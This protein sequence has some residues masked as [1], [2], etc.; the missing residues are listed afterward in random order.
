MWEYKE[1]YVNLMSG[2]NVTVELNRLG[3][4][5]WEC[6]S[7]IGSPGAPGSPFEPGRTFYF[8]RRISQD[9]VV[10]KMQTPARECNF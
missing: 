9:P 10:E 1:L 2:C 5:G 6:I 4:L 8:K 7:V 3:K